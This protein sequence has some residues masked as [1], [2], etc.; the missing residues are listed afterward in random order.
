MRPSRACP[1]IGRRGLFAIAA[2]V[3][4][5]PGIVRAQGHGGVALVIGNSKYRWEASLPNAKRDAADLARRFQEIGLRTALVEDAG[6]RTMTEALDR[7]AAASRGA[8]LACLYFAGH[9]AT[10]STNTYLVPVDSDLDDPGAVKSLVAMRSVVTAAEPAKNRFMV[11]DNCRNNPSD[12]WRQQEAMDRARGKS[13]HLQGD[14]LVLPRNTV[15]MYSTAPGRVALDGRP[16]QNSP[17]AAVL[18]R[19]LAAKSVDLFKLNAA[20]RRDLL[21][22]TE[23][24]Q[25]MWGDNTFSQSYEMRGPAAAAA[26]VPARVV[27]ASRIVDLKNA[28]AF[29]KEI[30]STLPSGIVAVRPP[31][32]APGAQFVGAYRFAGRGDV[33]FLWIVLS[34]PESGRAEIIMASR[35]AGQPFWRYLSASVTG[36]TLEAQSWARGPRYVLRWSDRQ[37]GSVSI[38]PSPDTVN[39][40]TPYNGRFTRL[41]G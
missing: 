23:G 38:F 7:F 35:D 25:L 33:P 16:G 17:F 24:R 31:D 32:G 5:A 3:L 8:E 26:A 19:R 4:A 20:V 18:L 22:E 12:G 21:I 11:F 9:G 1:A 29:A 40:S 2:G 30:N 6:R 28:Y 39:A 34:A 10:W 14:G 41:D 27:P 13:G 15:T 37:S 36:D